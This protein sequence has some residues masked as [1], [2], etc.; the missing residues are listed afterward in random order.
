MPVPQRSGVP[1][2]RCSLHCSFHAVQVPDQQS[3]FLQNSHLKASERAVLPVLQ[4]YGTPRDQR[5]QDGALP[6]RLPDQDFMCQLEDVEEVDRAAHAAAAQVRGPDSPGNRSCTARLPVVPALHDAACL[7]LHCQPC[8]SWSFPPGAAACLLW[9]AT[10]PDSQLDWSWSHSQDTA[11]TPGSM[12]N[13]LAAVPTSLWLCA[14]P[15]LQ[16]LTTEWVSGQQ[17]CA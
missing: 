13:A 5:G 8:G 10:P 2:D 3:E 15:D 14:L 7:H 16:H 12:T 17:R 6:A 11:L 4:S 1:S 9:S